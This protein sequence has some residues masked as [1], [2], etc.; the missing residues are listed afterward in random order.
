MLDD[1]EL[2]S[3]LYQVIARDS[4]KLASVSDDLGTA[5]ET[6][7][8][9]KKSGKLGRSNRDVLAIWLASKWIDLDA[10]LLK[11]TMQKRPG[12]CSFD[13]PAPVFVPLLTVAQ[14]AY[15]Q[16]SRQHGFDSH[17][18][19]QFKINRLQRFIIDVTFFYVTVF[20]LFL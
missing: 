5:P 1:K 4:L 19:C 18:R 15:V 13:V 10:E 8:R 9:W 2:I 17:W 16:S 6:I 14:A 7:S 3:L 12:E 11:R 20:P